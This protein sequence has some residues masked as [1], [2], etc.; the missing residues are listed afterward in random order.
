MTSGTSGMTGIKYFRV[1]GR[2]SDGGV[3]FSGESFCE[4]STIT[5]G[6]V[7]REPLSAFHGSFQGSN[8]AAGSRKSATVANVSRLKIKFHVSTHNVAF[9]R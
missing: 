5:G 2:R 4:I 8:R 9:Q 1:V 3:S 6:D 7:G